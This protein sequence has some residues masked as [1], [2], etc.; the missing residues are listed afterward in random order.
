MAVLHRASLF[1][2]F[3]LHA[4]ARGTIVDSADGADTI[5]ALDRGITPFDHEAIMARFL[6]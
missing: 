3:S 5:F 4:A 2:L 1:R 6:A